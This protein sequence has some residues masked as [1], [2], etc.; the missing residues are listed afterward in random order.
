[1]IVTQLIDLVGVHIMMFAPT[2][3]VRHP[4]ES[5]SNGVWFNLGEKY[6]IAFED[7][8]DG[9]RSMCEDLIVTNINPDIS[10]LVR[11]NQSVTV[12][13]RASS[14]TGCDTDDVIEIRN[15]ATGHL[16]LEVGTEDIDDYYPGFVCRYYPEHFDVNLKG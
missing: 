10:S 8:D 1:M 3:E 14:N 9:Y 6:Y 12:T 16:I 7:P 13:H 4:F 15:T 5:E 2:T 11:V